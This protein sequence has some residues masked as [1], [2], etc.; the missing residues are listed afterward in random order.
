LYNVKIK[1]TPGCIA[2]L[3]ANLTLTN[4]AVMTAVITPTNPT[5]NNYTDGIISIAGAANGTAPY[6]YSIDGGTSWA[7]SPFNGLAAGLYNVKIKDFTG[8]TATLNGSLILTQPD[9][10]SATITP[11]DV[12]QCFGNNNGSIV[13]SAPAGGSGSYE[14]TINGGGAWQADVNFTNLDTGNYN[15]QIRDG[16]ALFCKIVLNDA[17]TLTQ[18]IIL[19]AIATSTNLSCNGINDGTITISSQ[20]GGYGAYEYSID[21]GSGWQAGVNFTNLDTGTYNIQIRD[22]AY[23]SCVIIL[24]PALTISQPTSLSLSITYTV[25]SCTDSS[26]GSATISINGGV[27]PYIYLWD[28]GASQIT[29]TAL[30]LSADTYN[31]TVTDFHG[32]TIVGNIVIPDPPQFNV[33]VSLVQALKCNNDSDAVITVAETNGLSPYIYSWDD[34]YLQNTQNADSLPAG[35]YSV[36]VT[37]AKGCFDTASYTIIASIDTV[38]AIDLLPTYTFSSGDTTNIHLSGIPLGGV[39]SG[40]G[41]TPYDSTFHA[42]LA[43]VGDWP[44]TYTYT[45]PATH[46]VISDVDTIHVINVLGTISGISDADTVYYCYGDTIIDMYGHPKPDTTAIGWFDSTAV[47]VHN[48]GNNHGVFNPTLAGPGTHAVKFMYIYNSATLEVL[49]NVKVDS[50]GTP[51][52]TNIDPAYCFSN[53]LIT[54]NAINQYPPNGVGIWTG[55]SFNFQSSNAATFNVNSVGVGKDTV[56]Y[57]YTAPSHCIK[58]ISFP[59][60]VNPLPVDS[61]NVSD[62]LCANNPP[63]VI[64]GEDSNLVNVSFTVNDVIHNSDSVLFTPS[65]VGFNT[66]IYHY[67]DSATLCGNSYSKTIKVNTIPVLNMPDIANTY[68][69]NGDTA[70]I[71]GTANN[72]TLGNFWG[73]G[74]TAGPPDS[75]IAYFLPQIAGIGFDTIY[76]AYSDTNNCAD[77]MSRFIY[78]YDTTQISINGLADIRGYCHND[79]TVSLT[80]SPAGGTFIINNDT[81]SSFYPDSLLGRVDIIYRYSDNHQCISILID[82][83]HIYNF[84]QDDFIINDM[85]ANGPPVVVQGLNPDYINVTFTLNSTTY[86]DSFTLTPNALIGTN[87]ITYHFE[88]IVLQTI[89]DTLICHNDTTKSFRVFPL[90]SLSITDASQA[91]CYNGVTDTIHGTANNDTLGN[92]SGVA[93]INGLSDDGIAYFSPGLLPPFGASTVTTINYFYTDTN[94]CA[95]TLKKNIMV[96]DYPHPYIDTTG[97][98]F[99][100]CNDDDPVVLHGNPGGDGSIFYFNNA[101]H[102]STFDPG[103]YHP[104]TLRADTIIIRYQYT[105]YPT[106]TLQCVNDTNYRFLVHPLPYINFKAIDSCSADI[107]HFINQSVSEPIASWEW[108]FGPNDTMNT[109]DADHHYGIGG[110]QNISLQGTTIYGCAK[111]KDSLLT[112]GSAPVALFT[113]KYECLDSAVRFFNASTIETGIINNYLWDFGD[114]SFSNDTFPTHLFADTGSYHVTLTA[115]TNYGCDSS[116]TKTVR[117]RPMV[118]HYPYMQDFE[119]GHKGWLSESPVD[120]VNSWL[121]GTPLN[122]NVPLPVSGTHAYY[123]CSPKDS[124]YLNSEQSYVIGPCFNFDSLRRPMIKMKI[125]AG[126]E[127][128]YDGAV[129]QYSLDCGDSWQRL[130]D[131][132]DGIH[133]Y[134]SYSIEG[135]P[136]SQPLG[137]SGDSINGWIDVRHDLDILA[138]EHSVRL[139][140]AFGSSSSGIKKGFAFDDIWI[141]EKPRKVLFEHFTNAN[142]ATCKTWNANFNNWVGANRRDIIDIQYHTSYPSADELNTDNPADPGARSLYYGVSTA[143]Y[144]IMDGNYYRGLTYNWND[145]QNP[146]LKKFRT[147]RLEDPKFTVVIEKTINSGNVNVTVNYTPTETLIDTITVYIAVLEKLIDQTG[148]GT[149]GETRFRSV[150]KKMLPDAG[151]TN[152]TTYPNTTYIINQ[153]CSLSDFYNPADSNIVIVAFVQD[154]LTKEIYQAATTDT[155]DIN[156]EVLLMANAENFEFIVYPNPATDQLNIMFNKP[157]DAACSVQLYN[158]IGALMGSKPLQKGYNDHSLHVDKFPPGIYF[159]QVVSDKKIIGV[160]KIMIGR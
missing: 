43:G 72:D 91:Y 147:R 10:L 32:C 128:N 130:G 123:T 78:V 7:A 46:C 94:N 87:V 22:S 112:F 99:S 82:T 18:P 133:W 152:D 17:L 24:N 5:C 60:V 74:I 84:P 56:Y 122:P 36:S 141:G 64:T 140:I 58:Q 76:F 67:H 159:L 144:S 16:N 121:L 12:T 49:M 129:L 35:S 65:Q 75:G 85:C 90:P 54:V 13:M 71:H 27:A 101:L 151:G 6:T 131:I 155:W 102:S 77:T 3:N 157:L 50:V 98:K 44:V 8:C 104:D 111:T 40:A 26:D 127:I 39:F 59:F 154:E 69:V 14:Y 139:R 132:D 158:S 117:I 73:S 100:Y 134:N 86:N 110:Q 160:R 107:I 63:V 136:G 105:I 1:D 109:Q 125:Y 103:E 120:T 68:C 106:S 118:T 138:G 2:T 51:A 148:V 4:P 33:S 28:D 11:T 79:N 80:G 93:I 146:Y 135:N 52:Y 9:A 97:L 96:Y 81:I 53:D 62:Q 89:T 145:P 38:V 66:I 55:L 41:I 150:L 34:L 156:D 42:N 29:Q 113:W 57:K 124:S 92:F 70:T 48:L 37:D 108:T 114:S 116:V 47:Y 126:T 15:V 23:Q 153:S 45:H 25:I 143:P 115:T 61:F 142:D 19:S 88:N 20:N 137:W 30:N 83:A 119:T 21:S 95:D 31:C 149:N